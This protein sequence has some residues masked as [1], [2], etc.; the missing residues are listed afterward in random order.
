MSRFRTKEQLESWLAEFRQLGYSIG[1][2]LRVMQQDTVDGA[3]A[4]LVTIALADVD[5]TVYIQ[6]AMVGDAH[7]VVTLQ[8]EEDV[9]LDAAGITRYATDMVTTSALCAF[10]EARSRALDEPVDPA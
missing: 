3:N 10:L 1:G 8:C 6:P 4:G 5:T 9:V 2:E 7:W